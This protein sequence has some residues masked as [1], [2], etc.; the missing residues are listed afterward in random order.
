MNEL[1]KK[2]NIY[3]SPTD[4]PI[5]IYKVGILFS[6]FHTLYHYTTIMFPLKTELPY[7]GPDSGQRLLLPVSAASASHRGC[8]G[9]VCCLSWLDWS[10]GAWW[11]TWPSWGGGIQKHNLFKV[12]FKKQHALSYSFWGV[13]VYKK[14]VVCSVWKKWL[15]MFQSMKNQTIFV[16]RK[17]SK[18]TTMRYFLGPDI[19]RRSAPNNSS[20][21]RL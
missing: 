14:Y 15:K 8:R 6:I 19:R 1:S 5:T 17:T 20:S 4:Q 9:A 21:S 16:C 3:S 7:Q 13:H 10:V 2:Q 18:K 12:L 11:K